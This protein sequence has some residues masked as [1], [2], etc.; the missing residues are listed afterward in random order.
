M[1]F[2]GGDI[3]D[4]SCTHD[5]LGTNVFFAVAGQDSTY[6]TGGYR[7]DDSA[8]NV[9]GN[10]IM[11]DKMN[12][13]RSS[14]ECTIAMEMGVTLEILSAMASS[15]KTGTW[16]FTN[17]N[18]VIYTLVGKPVGDLN[19]NGNT[20]QIDLKVMGNSNALTVVQ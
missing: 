20:S 19:G 9:T 6:D 1:T 17:I 16:T 13:K 4:I 3:V 18:G 2:Q 12:A 7:S 15:T 8:D 11:I 10:G 5:D 14:F